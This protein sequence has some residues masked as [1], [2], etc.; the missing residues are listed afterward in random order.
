MI[1][2][3]KSRATAD[4]IMF[5]DVAKELLAHMGKSF[6][7]RGIITLEQLPDAIAAL[8]K[9]AAASREA[10]REQAPP[11]ED[12]NADAAQMPMPVSL[13][14][15]AAPLVEQLERSLSASQPVIWES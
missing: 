5:G 8:K 3:F 4:T 15:R 10:Q 7:A 12:E 13:A 9:A 14:Q 11:D 1:I 6:D 2:T